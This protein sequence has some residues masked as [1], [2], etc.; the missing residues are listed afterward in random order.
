MD[1]PG[2]G[3]EAQSRFGGVVADGDTFISRREL[4]RAY[5][6]LGYTVS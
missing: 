5:E 6:T 3:W 2:A 1:A 4:Q